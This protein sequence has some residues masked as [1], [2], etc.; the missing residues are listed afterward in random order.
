MQFGEETIIVKLEDKLV[1]T[2]CFLWK[3]TG[4]IFSKQT[5]TA[6]G[7]N[8]GNKRGFSA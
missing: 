7:L 5:S 8:E 3:I 6:A 2:E 1:V 4:N